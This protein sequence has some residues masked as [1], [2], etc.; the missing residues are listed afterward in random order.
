[1]YKRIN[2]TRALLAASGVMA[3]MAVSSATADLLENEVLLLWNSLD[4]EGESEAIR[5]A[6]LA[7][8]PGV[9]DL[10]LAIVPD[11]PSD[12]DNPHALA[13][14][15]YLIAPEA[16]EQFIRQPVVGFLDT[17]TAAD[18]VIAFV[19][20]RGLPVLVTTDFD[21]PPG[22][23]FNNLNSPV[24]SGVEGRLAMLGVERPLTD[25]VSNPYRRALN[26]PFRD[27]L[28]DTCL[29]G[30][31]FLV[32]RLDGSRIPGSQTHVQVIEALIERSLNLTLN[33]YL[34]TF[35]LDENHHGT[36]C[37]FDTSEAGARFMYDNGW[38]V[39]YDTTNTFLHGANLASGQPAQGCDCVDPN[40]PNADD[41]Q[42]LTDELLYT[43]YPEIVHATL[44][45]NHASNQ[46][47]P[48][49]ESECISRDYVRDY[50]AHPAAFFTS[51]ESFNGKTMHTGN[52]STS[53]GSVLDWIAYAGGS[54]G[55][56]NVYGAQ[57]A[58]VVKSD[59]V[60]ANLYEYGMSWGESV[61][62]S[63]PRLGGIQAAIGDPLATVT[64]YDPDLNGDGY[65]DEVDL[66]LFLIGA[67]PGAD[68]NGDGVIDG[69]DQQIIEDAIAR[70]QCPVSTVPTGELGENPYGPGDCHRWFIGSPD[71][72]GDLND[73]TRIDDTDVGIIEDRLGCPCPTYDYDGDG[74]VDKD[75]VQF[76]QD[77]VGTG[78][79]EFADYNVN[80]VVDCDDIYLIAANYCEQN[81]NPK[82]DFTCDGKVNHNDVSYVL[83]FLVHTPEYNVNGDLVVDC[84]DIFAVLD[85]FCEEDCIP[86]YDVNCD[87]KVNVTDALDILLFI[88]PE[89]FDGTHGT[90]LAYG[91]TQGCGAIDLLRA[92]F[93]KS[94]SRTCYD[95]CWDL[96]DDCKIDCQD[97]EL[98]EA[99]IAIV[100]GISDPC[101]DAGCGECP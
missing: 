15:R 16:F 76:V 65:V 40:D 30:D 86:I 74:L 27:F 90:C 12:P 54:F 99:F 83:Q 14:T 13:V 26:Y 48:G 85:N 62:S 82:F 34:V 25:T 101:P 47:C 94:C 8:H 75:D 63:M 71:C 87:A 64:V 45:K 18:D 95:P 28:D 60:V 1:M 43:D 7:A 61:F 58:N 59:E 33:K 20:T 91:I 70:G 46:I 72:F 84:N 69:E 2:A 92:A 66:L 22:G 21:L 89:I 42:W 81:C 80:G 51:R 4:S 73:D 38:C 35:V 11:P 9:L 37:R 44:G 31:M 50:N 5:D 88:A 56:A 77:R 52:D 36:V 97:E 100:N 93:C 67:A 78:M 23:H 3:A 41:C 24:L 53:H 39:Y 49:N 29:K 57:S 96:N 79:A 6:Y 68:I 10:D 32:S 19:T 17:N 55:A 98:L